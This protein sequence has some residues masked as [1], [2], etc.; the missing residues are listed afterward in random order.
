[1][2]PTELNTRSSAR[3]YIL[4]Y[5]HMYEYVSATGRNY[6]IVVSI[7]ITMRFV[8]FVSILTTMV[9][10]WLDGTWELHLFVVVGRVLVFYVS[11]STGLTL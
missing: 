4:L 5:M 9:S 6:T 1:M 11:T 3:L 8:A 10:C 2:A 7:L